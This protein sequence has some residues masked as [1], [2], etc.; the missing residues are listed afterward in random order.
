MSFQRKWLSGD[1][2]LNRVGLYFK[3]GGGASTP[4]DTEDAK[5]IAKIAA[6]RWQQYQNT[7]VPAE[8]KYIDEMRNYDNP[9]RMAQVT[10]SAQAGTRNAFS[11]A[12]SADIGNM[13]SAGINPQSG[14][15]KAAISDGTTRMAEAETSNTSKT[16][17][18]IQDQKVKGL[19][20]VVA[21]GMGKSGEALAGLNTTAAMSTQDAQQQ[22]IRDY[23]DSA[24][25]KQAIGTVVG[26]GTRTA[27]EYGNK[28]GW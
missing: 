28:G 8:N 7:Y 13:T 9:D 3:G 4:D 25:N 22:A 6:E 18:A 1:R 19:Q 17:Q 20:N 11:E 24:A 26:A 5:A 27:I 21:I 16:Q 23:N 2:L 15:F 14:T 10:Q 12:I